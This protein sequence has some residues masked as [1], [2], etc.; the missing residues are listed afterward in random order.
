MVFAS[1]YPRDLLASCRSCE[2]GMGAAL[3]M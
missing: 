1:A 2:S 3:T